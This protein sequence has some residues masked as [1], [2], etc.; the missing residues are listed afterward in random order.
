MNAKKKTGLGRG[1]SALLDGAEEALNQDT[2]RSD[3]VLAWSQGYIRTDHIETNPYQPRTSFEQ[4]ALAELS[5]SIQKQGIIQPVTVRRT[6]KDQYQLISGERRLKAAMMAGLEEIPAFIR[7][8]DDNQML[9]L[10]LVENLQR[11]DLN[12]MDIA[13]SLQRL[14]EEYEYSQE[15]MA[16]KLG[17]KRTTI[18]NYLRL[19]KLPPEIQVALR[20]EQIS[21]GHARALVNITDQQ[22][23]LA[24]L[25]DIISKGLSVRDVEKIVRDLS[26]PIEKPKPLKKQ[27][28]PPLLTM[29]DHIEKAVGGKISV[30]LTSAGKG[31]I[32][33]PFRNDEQLEAIL[34]TLAAKHSF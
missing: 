16:E 17:K 33:L 23:Q 1:L 30:H 12:S 18:T 2:V 19:L 14:A 28:A 34:K 7:T 26:Q 5:A 6:G 9:E 27:L 13:I 21:M 10:A 31:S 29:K 8:A 3:N 20:D 4:E 15:T 22:T 32:R 11:K 25:A 24:I